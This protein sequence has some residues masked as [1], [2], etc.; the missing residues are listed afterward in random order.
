MVQESASST[1]VT[2]VAPGHP[3]VPPPPTGEAYKRA[4]ATRPL[5]LQVAALRRTAIRGAVSRSD[6]EMEKKRE[7]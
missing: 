6:G 5:L 1:S 4:I 2:L 3:P 7:N